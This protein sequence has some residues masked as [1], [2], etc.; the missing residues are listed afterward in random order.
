MGV[1][2]GIGR[3]AVFVNL[4]VMAIAGGQQITDLTLAVAAHNHTAASIPGAAF[5]PVQVVAVAL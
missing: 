4:A 1:V 3:A 5:N 2:Y